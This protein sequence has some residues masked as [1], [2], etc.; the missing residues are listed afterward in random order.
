MVVTFARNTAQAGQNVQENVQEKLTER[1]QLILDLMHEDNTIS[2]EQMSKRL[3]VSSKT[4]QRAVESMPF[5]VHREGAD[6]GGHWQIDPKY[7]R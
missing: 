4:V 6:F 2:Y 1:Q 5:A 7:L 3:R